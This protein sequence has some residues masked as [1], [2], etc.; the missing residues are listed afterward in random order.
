[1]LERRLWGTFDV[2]HLQLTDRLGGVGLVP[3]A[4][5]NPK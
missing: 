4:C 3:E 5:V 2:A 1:M